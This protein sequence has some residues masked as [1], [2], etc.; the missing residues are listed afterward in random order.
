M[1]K[2]PHQHDKL[3]TRLQ[4]A[5]YLGPAH[6]FT[7]HYVWIIATCK[8]TKMCSVIFTRTPPTIT[9]NDDLNMDDLFPKVPA[10]LPTD[11]YLSP[12]MD[13]TLND[14]ATDETPPSTL[15]ISPIQLPSDLADNPYEQD[16]LLDDDASPPGSPTSAETSD[17]DSAPASAP[18]SPT[19]TCMHSLNNHLAKRTQR[20]IAST[21]PEPAPL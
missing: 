8:V 16:F 1:L 7:V 6:Y 13:E 12:G 17:I 10:E 9:I 15:P 3:G 21:R 18:L 11:D 4:P 14:P 19:P 5:V 2:L 20:S